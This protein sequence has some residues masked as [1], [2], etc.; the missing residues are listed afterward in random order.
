MV[1]GGVGWLCFI[2][3]E[4][5]SRAGKS[6]KEDRGFFPAS[7]DRPR[8]DSAGIEL[9]RRGD[10]DGAHGVSLD[11][12]GWCWGPGCNRPIVVPRGECGNAVA[13]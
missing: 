1:G 13:S 4:F 2:G 9:S 6:H 7:R 11:C 8:M 5:G 3:G 12:V 10:R